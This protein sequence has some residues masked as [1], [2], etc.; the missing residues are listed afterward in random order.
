LRKRTASVVALRCNPD[1]SAYCLKMIRKPMV[2]DERYERVWR[3]YAH[4]LKGAY[5]MNP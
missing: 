2:D 3:D 1:Q 5:K 4:A